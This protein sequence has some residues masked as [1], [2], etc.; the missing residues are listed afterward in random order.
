[1]FARRNAKLV[2]IVAAVALA[3]W[4]VL[5]GLYAVV[6]IAVAMT[7]VAYNR[8]RRTVSAHNTGRL[9]KA[10]DSRADYRT[11]P[12]CERSFGCAVCGQIAGRTELLASDGPVTEPSNASE[13]ATT[14]VNE[15]LRPKDNVMLE[16][17]T[18][19]GLE[20]QPVRAEWVEAVVEASAEA[21]AS[22]LYNMAHSY[23]PFYCPE[24][25]ASYCG[26]HWHWS[27]FE[28]G[29]SSGIGGSCERGHFHVLRM[30][31]HIHVRILCV[32]CGKQT[33]AVEL[34]PPG[35]YPASLQGDQ[36]VEIRKSWDRIRKKE[37]WWLR[38]DGPAAGSGAG[39]AIGEDK[40]ERIAASFAEPLNYARIHDAGFYDDA[41]FCGT[42]GK[43][44]CYQHWNVSGGEVGR[45]P[46]GHMKFLDSYYNPAHDDD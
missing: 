23:A 8:R 1:M 24:C 11:A 34:L 43:P 38:Y 17:Q 21:D 7:L 35:Q 14:D 5:G 28:V 36:Y 29:G 30:P 22:A 46:M 25:S 9:A 42:C 6:A 13:E 18:C 20:A 12:G 39:H 16:V 2:A 3:C 45:C 41:G 19:Y 26:E 44:Y 37:P 33:A 10:D 27:S 4:L 31:G 40:A 15:P 32:V